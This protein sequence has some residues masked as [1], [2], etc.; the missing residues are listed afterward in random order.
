MRK[1]VDKLRYTNG[2]VILKEGSFGDALYLI[3]DGKVEIYKTIEGKKS[4]VGYLEKGA[5][6][7]ELSFIDKKP[8]PASAAAVGDVEIGVIDKEFLEYEI[9]KMSY[10]FSLVLNALAE[11]LRKTTEEY[12]ALKSENERLKAR[13]TV[14]K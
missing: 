6:L 4:V 11:R 8:R 7:G 12:A 10:E 9:N 13:S 2:Q 1:I 3:L 5:I 14:I